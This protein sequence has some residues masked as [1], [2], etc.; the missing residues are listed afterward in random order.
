[1]I[2]PPHF[3]PKGQLTLLVLKL[4]SEADEVVG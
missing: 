1:M 2:P 4:P 3:D